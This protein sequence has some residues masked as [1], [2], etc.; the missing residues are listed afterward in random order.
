MVTYTT[1]LI[2]QKKSGDSSSWTMQDYLDGNLKMV[3]TSRRAG[4][5]DVGM[6]AWIMTL[7][8]TEYPQVRFTIPLT[9]VRNRF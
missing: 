9:L 4:S 1:E 6:V 5:N 7:K 3:E 8:T 2:V